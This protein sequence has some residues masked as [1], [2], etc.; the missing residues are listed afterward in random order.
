[1]N[2]NNVLIAVKSAYG[3]GKKVQNHSI[4]GKILKNLDFYYQLTRQ[5]QFSIDELSRK[6]N[7]L[8]SKTDLITQKTDT[9]IIRDLLAANLALDDI[10]AAG[11]LDSSELLQL[12]NMYRVNTGLP[13]DGTTCGIPNSQI[14]VMSYFGLFQIGILENADE[15]LLTRYVL[16]MFATGEPIVGE[17][18]FPEFY[19]EVFQPYIDKNRRIALFN[20]LPSNLSYQ[21]A[22]TN[23]SNYGNVKLPA[24]AKQIA[25]DLLEKGNVE[26]LSSDYQELEKYY[27]EEAKRLGLDISRPELDLKWVSFIKAMSQWLNPLELYDD[28]KFVNIP[29]SHAMIENY[30]FVQKLA[31][32]QKAAVD[33]FWIG[34]DLLSD[35]T[36][37]L[38]AKMFAERVTEMVMETAISSIPKN[39]ELAMFELREDLRKSIEKKLVYEFNK[40]PY[41]NPWTSL[42]L[43]C[44][45]ICEAVGTYHLVNLATEGDLYKAQYMARRIA[46]HEIDRIL[47]LSYNK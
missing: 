7:K 12:K 32:T 6:I 45:M 40:S 5:G 2:L 38:P 20:A 16:H 23:A 30:C 24:L 3:F 18:L 25:K 41:H 27:Q 43:I 9:L 17:T 39:L 22:D 33:L 31:C 26:A 21:N 47:Q 10:K 42:R 34:S 14:C 19:D 15:K 4:Q 11:V 13:M 46:M 8:D 36:S 1:M 44:L 37:R 28:S 29:S 35:S